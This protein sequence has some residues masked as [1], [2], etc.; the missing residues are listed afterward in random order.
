MKIELRNVKHAVFAS[1]ETPCMSASIYIDGKKA[2]EV[3]NDGCG[4]PYDFSNFET[5]RRL[6]EYGASLP[7]LTGRYG[8]SRSETGFETFEMK[9]NAETLIC[10][11]FSAWALVKEYKRLTSRRILFVR[12]GKIYETKTLSAEQI[13]KVLSK[14]DQVR[15]QLKTDTVLNLLPMEEGVRVF[16]DLAA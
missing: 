7:P 8:S 16:R 1:H 13:A 11:A 15:A 4:G 6:N 5:E 12:D 10:D 9:Q 14:P 3:S 2:G